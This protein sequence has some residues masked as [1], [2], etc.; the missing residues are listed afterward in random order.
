FFHDQQEQRASHS[1]VRAKKKFSSGQQNQDNSSNNKSLSPARPRGSLVLSSPTKAARNGMLSNASMKLQ[2]ARAADMMVTST[3]KQS[4]TSSLTITMQQSLL[5]Q[6]QQSL[7]MTNNESNSS[8]IHIEPSAAKMPES[9]QDHSYD[10]SSDATARF[11][12]TTAPAT[13]SMRSIFDNEQSKINPFGLPIRRPDSRAATPQ[14][15]SAQ[16]IWRRLLFEAKKKY[17]DWRRGGD[18][19]VAVIGHSPMKNAGQQSLFEQQQA[20]SIATAPSLPGKQQLQA[21]SMQRSSCSPPRSPALQASSDRLQH[22]G[23]AQH[24]QNEASQKIH[25][26]MVERLDFG[27]PLI[28]DFFYRRLV[29]AFKEDE[30]EGEQQQPASSSAV[31]A[32]TEEVLA[33]A[34]H[35]TTT[36]TE[37]QPVES[38]TAPTEDAVEKQQ[39][40]ADQK[41]PQK[42]AP[43]SNS[44]PPKQEAFLLYLA[45]L[46]QHPEVSVQEFK[47]QIEREYWEWHFG[48]VIV[49]EDQYDV[50]LE[51]LTSAHGMASNYGGG[52]GGGIFG[53]NNYGASTTSCNH[54]NYSSTFTDGFGGSFEYGTTTNKNMSSSFINHFP[55]KPSHGFVHQNTNL[56]SIQESATE[57]HNSVLKSSASG[58]ASTTNLQM[59]SS[60]TSANDSALGIVQDNSLSEM[61]NSRT[62]NQLRSASFNLA[63]NINDGAVIAATEGQ[64]VV[65]GN[66][67]NT[68]SNAAAAPVETDDDT[69]TYVE[70]A[71][72]TTTQSF[73]SN[74]AGMSNFVVGLQDTPTVAVAVDTANISALASCED[75]SQNV[76]TTTFLEDDFIGGGKNAEEDGFFYQYQHD[77]LHIPPGTS[78]SN[79]TGQS[80]SRP[81]TTTSWTTSR[82]R[83]PLYTTMYSEFGTV[84]ASGAGVK[85]VTVHNAQR[86]VDEHQVG[87][88]RGPGD[89][90]TGKQQLYSNQQIASMSLRLA[91]KNALETRELNN[92]LNN[93][94]Y[95]VSPINVVDQLARSPNLNQ[96]YSPQSYLM[97]Q[98]QQGMLSPGRGAQ[99]QLHQMTSPLLQQVQKKAEQQ[100]RIPSFVP[101]PG[102][103]AR[104]KILSTSS[105]DHGGTTNSSSTAAP[106][107]LDQNGP[108]AVAGTNT[109][110]ANNK[111][112]AAKNV[113]SNSLMMSL[114]A[115]TSTNSRHNSVEL[116]ANHGP[117]MRGTFLR[118]GHRT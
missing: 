72:Q 86:R 94:L 68:P 26:T 59:M 64:A 42:S 110:T 91:R 77:L 114:A 89:D 98:H 18:E 117:V 7:Q 100:T 84:A 93:N 61:A 1:P 80:E 97:Q 41:S 109:S 49:E 65:A 90:Q 81:T 45:C 47:E 69:G 88:T 56:E 66:Y 5:D 11:G 6:E 113:N 30:V 111:H 95:H 70:S 62:N 28:E 104:K 12:L 13:T 53:N 107:A 2:Q 82:V 92:K 27:N 19:S 55:D 16:S 74:T 85:G 83:T 33:P 58:A 17:L 31:V 73:L 79:K 29:K 52:L 10:P 105:T 101:K 38:T 116:D 115:P 78:F 35:E 48:D 43:P 44:K 96:T 40:K 20:S 15:S 8:S 22:Q 106:A 75:D 108:H 25:T 87:T 32:T 60:C 76:T 112:V 34:D 4:L 63:T 57:G 37:V 118:R 21:N 9:Y 14:Q 99:Q 67:I 71:M 39:A 103:P 50:D 54:M 24:Q 102:L 3:S 51:N 36:K 23:S 46:K